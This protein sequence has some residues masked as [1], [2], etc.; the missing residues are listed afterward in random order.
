MWGSSVQV[1]VD[2]AIGRLVQCCEACGWERWL[3]VIAGV[4]ASAVVLGCCK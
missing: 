2:L 1:G 4:V 3:L